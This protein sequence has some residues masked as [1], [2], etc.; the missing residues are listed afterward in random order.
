MPTTTQPQN[1]PT[2]QLSNKTALLMLVGIIILAGFFYF[3][4]LAS[5][6]N[7]NEYYTAAVESML[8]SWH[9]FF[10]VAA[11]PGGSVTV[12]KPP[13]GL[14]V[15]AASAFLFGVNGF[16]VMLPNIVA[17]LLIIPL[18]YHLVKKYFGTEAGLI[19][20][21]VWAITPV[22]VATVRNN[23]MDGMLT[24]TLLLA[25]WMFIL[26]TEKGQSRYLWAGAVLVGLGFNIKML[27]ALLP[28]PALYALYFL[29]A[30][31]GWGKKLLNLTLATVILLIVSFAWVAAVDLTP[32]DQRPYIGSST[33]N[34]VMEL[35]V[36]HNGLNRLFGGKGRASQS[37]PPTGGQVSQD[38]SPTQGQ[39][40]PRQRSQNPLPNALPNAQAG[41]QN[42]PSSTR[43]SHEMGRQ[44]ISRFFEPPLAKEMSWLLPF[45]LLGLVVAAVSAKFRLPL[46]DSA[47]L[48]V[49]L[50]GGW[51]VTCLVFFS[52]AAF[53]HAYYMIMLAP[54]LGAVVGMGVESLRRVGRDRPSLARWLLLAGGG[55]TL[56]FQIGLAV[57]FEPLAW[58]MVFPVVLLVVGGGGLLLGDSQTCRVGAQVTLLALL[59]IP[60]AWTGMTSMNDQDIH[61]PSAYAGTVKNEK[62]PPRDDEPR[63]RAQED[64]LAF[65]Q[66]NT[67]DMKYLLAVP[68]ANNGAAFV[69]ETERPVLYMGGFTGSDSVVSVEDLRSMVEAGELRYVL[70]STDPAIGKWLRDTCRPV[71]RFGNNQPVGQL[72]PQ[73]GQ[74]PR[75]KQPPPG[76]RRSPQRPHS[77]QSYGPL[78]DCEI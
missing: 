49:V 48:G 57:Q 13:L 37:A 58:W 78:F 70:G 71:P 61:L 43:F 51:L 77:K 22:V 45:A 15:E 65:L 6:G 4:D 20:A 36:G 56:A 3:Y 27:Q 19:A 63:S 17:G 60:L 47:H 1:H 5:L 64:L 59:V 46:E 31:I 50:W 54:A 29:G 16:A 28:L 62:K 7:A 24:F 33:D 66:K 39:P 25:A 14:W 74:Q 41:N 40:S 21:L 9:N 44:G 12:D 10:F 75:G 23:T 76:A 68:R 38:A 73:N 55:L 11:E 52:V 8:Q 72:S 42:Q 69:I 67:Q 18:L 53:F 35:I 2:T 34:T 26:A 30:K 32:A